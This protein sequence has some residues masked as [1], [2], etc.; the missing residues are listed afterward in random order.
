MKIKLNLISKSNKLETL[1]NGKLEQSKTSFLL[2]ENIALYCG[3]GRFVPSSCTRVSQNVYEMQSRHPIF[4][5]LSNIGK[6]MGHSC[7]DHRGGLTIETFGK[8]H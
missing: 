5:R 2:K 4:C 3:L 8:C 1:K 7:L 6:V